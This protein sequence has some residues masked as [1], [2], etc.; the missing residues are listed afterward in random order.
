MKVTLFRQDDMHF[1]AQG[2]S[3]QQI[4]LDGSAAEGGRS[5]GIRPMETVLAALG[6]CSAIDV[7]SILKKSRQ[8][9]TD[10][11]IDITAERG[12][13]VPAVFR[14]IH[15]HYRIVGAGLTE[16]M[17]ARAI[18]LSADKYCSVSRM[19]ECTAKI[20]HSHEIISP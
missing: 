14:N 20:T 12:D 15:I 18:S 11:T 4:S 16:K 17:V 13:E 10:C 8:T 2:D 6:G 19:L 1:V 7:M 9:V 3:G 5:R